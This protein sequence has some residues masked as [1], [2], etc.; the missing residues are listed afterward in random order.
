MPP[1]CLVSWSGPA[2]PAKCPDSRPVSENVTWLFAST[3]PAPPDGYEGG[4]A[5][6][7]SQPSFAPELHAGV[8]A[9]VGTSCPVEWQYTP[10]QVAVDASYCAQGAFG[11]RTLPPAPGA[12]STSTTR[13]MCFA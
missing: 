8:T 12:S 11:P 5:W 2:R 3:A 9:N 1:P 13:S 4:S 7:P 10:L 6:Q